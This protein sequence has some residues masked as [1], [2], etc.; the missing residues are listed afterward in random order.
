MLRHTFATHLIH[1]GADLKS[2]QTLLGHASFTTMQR[3]VHA[4]QSQLKKAVKLLENSIPTE[5]RHRQ[6]I[7][8]RKKLSKP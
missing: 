2:L 3:Y 5:S 7:K 4:I 8:D 6:K 1:K